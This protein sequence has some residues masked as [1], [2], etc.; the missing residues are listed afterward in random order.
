MNTL[1]EQTTWSCMLE[2]Y[3]DLQN[4]AGQ[5][6][7]LRSVVESTQKPK[8]TATD[9]TA[10][11]RAVPEVREHDNENEEKNEDDSENEKLPD[12]P[13]DDDHDMQQEM[14][15]EPDITTTMSSG[16]GEK[17]PRNT[18]ERVYEETGDDEIAEATDHTYPTFRRSSEAKD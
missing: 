12:K 7:N 17:S 2:V 15:T 5:K 16:R 10:D 9:D 3:D 11:L 4:T 8:S 1:F 18:R 6:K 14:L 13:E